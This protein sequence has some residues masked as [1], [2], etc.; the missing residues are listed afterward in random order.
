[1]VKPTRDQGLSWYSLQNHQGMQTP[2][3]HEGA[4]LRKDLHK[5]PDKYLSW[6]N[7]FRIWITESHTEAA[8]LVLFTWEQNFCDFTHLN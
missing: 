7:I 4:T 2:P 1:M 6:E 8:I 3:P 5:W